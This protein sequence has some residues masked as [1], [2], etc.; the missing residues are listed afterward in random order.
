MAARSAPPVF[1]FSPASLGRAAARHGLLLIAGPLR[2]KTVAIEALWSR[3]CCV[4]GQSLLLSLAAFV[5]SVLTQPL[6]LPFPADAS[7]MI[8]RKG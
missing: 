5:F 1:Y 3:I 2:L 6:A 4:K 8:V 7:T